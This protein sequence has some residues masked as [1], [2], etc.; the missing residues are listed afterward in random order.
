MLRLKVASAVMCGAGIAA[1]SLSVSGNG[2]HRPV[3]PLVLGSIAVACGVVLT[4]LM[5]RA[6]RK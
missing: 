2:G 5:R 4:V 3:I 1:I 6:S